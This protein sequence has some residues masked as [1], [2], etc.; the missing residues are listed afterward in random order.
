[1]VN[2]EKHLTQSNPYGCEEVEVNNLF[3]VCNR[4]SCTLQDYNKHMSR[5]MIW[6]TL[7]FVW[8]GIQSDEAHIMFRSFD[9]AYWGTQRQRNKLSITRNFISIPFDGNQCQI[10]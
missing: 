1:M 2:I 4:Q 7:E 3:I 10:L 5:G 8:E 6:T 9:K